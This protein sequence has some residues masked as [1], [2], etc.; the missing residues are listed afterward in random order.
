MVWTEA[1]AEAWY[2]ARSLP[3]GCNFVPSTAVNQL[4]MW[5]A[6]SFD[7]PTIDRELAYAAGLGMNAVRVFLHDL[8]WADPAGCVARLDAFLGVAAGHGI[9]VMPV[10]FESCWEPEPVAGP[11]LPP[12]PGVHNSRWVQGPGMAALADPAARP[13]LEAYARGVV[14]AFATDARILAWDVWNE[15]DNGPEVTARDHATLAAKAELVLPLLDAAFDWVRSARPSQP[16]TSAVWSGDWSSPLTLTPIQRCQLERSDILSFHNYDGP[17][18]FAEKAGWLAARGRPVLCTEYLA[19]PR[20]STFAAIVPVA[21]G[22]RVGLF[23]WGLVAG[24]I[25]TNLPWSSVDAPIL[26]AVPEPWFHDICHPDGT[27][28][29]PAEAVLLRG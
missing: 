9:A 4:E 20:G 14:A 19:R 23:N 5:Q 24:R 18:I 28:H 27:V 6:G 3:F 15:P 21:R 11:Q 26:G 2:A 17:E 29:D 16:L 22:Q 13:R 8:L 7:L 12:K 1:A 25:Q 10:L